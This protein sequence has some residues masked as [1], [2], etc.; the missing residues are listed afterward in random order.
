[1]YATNSKNYCIG[2]PLPVTVATYNDGN[3]EG[4]TF[5]C[6]PLQVNLPP[7][8]YYSALATDVMDA[9]ICTAIAHWSNRIQDDYVKTSVQN[10]S[11][12]GL[13]TISR[14]LADNASTTAQ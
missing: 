7:N 3:G 10:A 14:R 13:Q 9:A 11:L 6:D 5:T 2:E 8:S 4:Y 1:M 12:S